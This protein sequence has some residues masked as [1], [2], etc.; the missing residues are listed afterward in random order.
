MFNVQ[1]ETPPDNNNNI[2]TG[3]VHDTMQLFN[4][5]QTVTQGWQRVHAKLL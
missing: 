2:S 4:K 1:A 5:I 3:N